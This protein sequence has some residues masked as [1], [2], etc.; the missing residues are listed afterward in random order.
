MKFFSVGAV[1]DDQPP[2][3]L[4]EGE[5][6]LSPVSLPRPVPVVGYVINFDNLVPGSVA[7]I[8]EKCQ[9]IE[10]HLKEIA[11]RQ[12]TKSQMSKK[13]VLNAC[14]SF[15]KGECSYEALVLLEA[16]EASKKEGYKK[17]TGLS[18]FFSLQG[19]T[20]VLVEKI[21]GLKVWL[22]LSEDC[23]RRYKSRGL[24]VR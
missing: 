11:Q 13:R 3:L 12:Q 23:G 7:V 1:S 20:D 2:V 10:K 18:Q 4:Q 8:E 5:V 9:E 24:G 19:D 17:T 16:D 15:L 22:V 6:A 14:L 21:I